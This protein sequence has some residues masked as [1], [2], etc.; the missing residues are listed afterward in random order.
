MK[1][2]KRGFIE[3]ERGKE[4]ELERGRVEKETGRNIS[5]R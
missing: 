5:S 4:G 1:I 2:N 3:W